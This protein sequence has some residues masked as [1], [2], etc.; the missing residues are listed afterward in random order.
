LVTNVKALEI[1]DF[2]ERDALAGKIADQYSEWE[3]L[4]NTWL[5]QKREIQEYIFAI[6]TRNTTNSALPWKN[7][8]HIPKLCQIRDNLHANYMAAL[9]PNDRPIRWE[10]DDESSEAK[11]K[12]E[13]IEAYM[14]NK[15][16]QGQFRTEVSK[17]VLDFIDY[18][19][20][21]AMSTFVSEKTHDED[22]ATDIPGFIGPKLVRISPLDIVFNPVSTSFASSPKIIR[23]M[24]TL[25][26]LKVEVEDHPEMQYQAEVF[27][28]L[29]EKR[30][31]LAGMSSGDFAKNEAFSFDGFSNWMS[32][33]QSDYV[34]I[35]DFYGDIFDPET[36][37]FKKNYLI[38][39]VDRSYVIRMAP[40]PSW[41]GNSGIHHA[42]WR[43][44][45]DN[46]YAMGPLDNL[47]GMQYRIDHLENAKADGWDMIIQPVI[48][49]TGFV[50][51]FDYGPGE[52]IYCEDEGNVEFMHPDVTLLNTNNEIAI[53]EMKM[54]EMAGAPK[55]AM[56]FRTPG[57]KTAYE[58]Q[59]LE[60][61]ANRVFLNKTAY[62]EEILI[63]PALNDMLETS[64]RNMGTSDLIR[65][66]DD[67]YGAVTFMKITKEDI[68]ARGKIRP[69]GARHF[70]RNANILQ[71]LTQLSNSPL[72]QDPAVN[73]HISGKALAH[74]VEDLLD[75]KRYNL[76][77]DN[78]RVLESAETQSLASAAQQK[79][80]EQMQPN[81]PPMVQQPSQGQAGAIPAIGQGK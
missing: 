33:F 44:R 8:T 78:I 26:T 4:R 42:G 40:N 79:V 77:Q 37:D 80:M 25:G 39:V 47:I 19:N 38:S 70:A 81:G 7:S 23:S 13:V 67:Q 72:G 41:L 76:V 73:A 6:D 2:L 71:N 50:E 9:F 56:G 16:R 51:D 22:T 15:L 58:M 20:C 66:T 45:P 65:V 14:E 34:E 59:I 1:C 27:E 63:E 48:K 68:T 53:Y 31:A 64:R 61:G 30:R 35:L 55:Q 10:G 21:F 11:E 17:C 29:R 18:G 28:K 46:L 52:R 74:V 3:S 62:F 36:N 49:V 43:V 60:Q 32:Y 5:D 57:E 75:L 12:R 69:I 54:E 24:K